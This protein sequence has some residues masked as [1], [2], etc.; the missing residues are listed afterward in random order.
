MEAEKNKANEV[1]LSMTSRL[2]MEGMNYTLCTT[3]KWNGAESCP[4]AMQ[5]LNWPVPQAD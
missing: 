3:I 1:T 2:V 5:F 4:K